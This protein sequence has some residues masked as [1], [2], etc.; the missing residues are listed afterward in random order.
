MSKP[1]ISAC[2]IFP[3]TKPEMILLSQ[4]SSMLSFAL[5]TSPFVSNA[6]ASC[7]S[8]RLSAEETAASMAI[9]RLLNSCC[10]A[11][12]CEISSSTIGT[13]CSVILICFRCS[14]CR[15]FIIHKT[16]SRKRSGRSKKAMNFQC[17]IKR[18]GSKDV[19]AQTAV[20][21]KVM[22]IEST[23]TRKEPVRSAL[24]SP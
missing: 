23:C 9:I 18:I 20:K 8:G 6:T 24:R 1:E 10:L 2:L 3:K 4:A 13:Y 17:A 21:N 19:H 11:R 15:V 5:S 22:F 16:M 7:A 12:T 14:S